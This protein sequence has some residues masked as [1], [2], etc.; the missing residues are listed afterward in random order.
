MATINDKEYYNS[1]LRDAGVSEIYRTYNL[2]SSRNPTERWTLRYDDLL[3]S[4]VVPVFTSTDYTS[5]TPVFERGQSTAI[6]SYFSGSSEIYKSIIYRE[7]GSPFTVLTGDA[8]PTP[9][10]KSGNTLLCSDYS[11]VRADIGDVRRFEVDEYLNLD[12]VT[13]AT[14]LKTYTEVPLNEK[15]STIFSYV[16]VRLNSER[17]SSLTFRILEKAVTLN[18]INEKGAI[19]SYAFIANILGRGGKDKSF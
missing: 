12:Y 17:F 6:E 1:L 19:N 5:I 9:F 7:K 11:A 8:N 13:S 18:E 15:E 3:L 16:S 2:A 10:I 4:K 14:D